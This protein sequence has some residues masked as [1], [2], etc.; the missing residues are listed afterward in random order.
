MVETA[1]EELQEA[2]C[3]EVGGEDEGEED[4]IAPTTTGR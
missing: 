3:I 2:G 4:V 1:L